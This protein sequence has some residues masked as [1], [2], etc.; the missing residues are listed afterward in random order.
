MAYNYMDESVLRN[1]NGVSTFDFN[2]NKVQQMTIE[3]LER[4]VH[5][6][7]VNGVPLNDIYHFALLRELEEL[8][9]RSNLRMVYDDIFAANGGPSSMPGVIINHQLEQKHGER[10]VEAHALRRVYA[11][12][13]L[14]DFDTDELS[15]QLAV[16]YHQDGIQ[17]GFGQ[18][19]Q[20]CHN[21]TM[22]GSSQT[23]ETYGKGK[24]DVK[25]LLKVV[26]SW[27]NN[28]GEY[29]QADRRQIEEMKQ[30]PVDY[31][32]HCMMLGALTIQRVKHDTRLTDIRIKEDYPLNNTQINRLTESLESIYQRNNHEPISLWQW[33][34]AATELHK[35]GR[36][37]LPMIIAQNVALGR[38]INQLL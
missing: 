36:T 3:T 1:A 23:A 26:G 22:L 13:K 34:N 9:A 31:H 14:L 4:T 17:V 38:F 28:A 15:T 27:L 37:D 6:D 11:N 21:L 35:A 20:I 18:H 2:Q 8:A 5:E 24:V 29:V 10:A 25:E 16:S 19:V 30:I 32:Q 33:Y 12:I 7:T